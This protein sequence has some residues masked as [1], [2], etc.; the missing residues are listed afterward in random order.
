MFLCMFLSVHAYCDA[1]TITCSFIP[2]K[3]VAR[4]ASATIAPQ[5]VIAVL[6]TQV[7]SQCTFINI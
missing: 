4:V 3:G 6:V 2:T 5:C 1:L 7:C